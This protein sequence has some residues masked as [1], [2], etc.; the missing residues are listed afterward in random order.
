M[1]NWSVV[2]L[3]SD[4]AYTYKINLEGRSRKLTFK[5][6]TR[7]N[8]YHFDMSNEDGTPL[9]AGI[10]MLPMNTLLN[11][12][13]LEQYGITGYF[14]LVP[15]NDAIAFNFVKPSELNQYYAFLYVYE[16]E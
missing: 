6:N 15:R 4:E 2:P 10:P 9:V 8:V 5:L 7:T 1:F 13:A 14:I 3:K 11:N 12:L 16:S